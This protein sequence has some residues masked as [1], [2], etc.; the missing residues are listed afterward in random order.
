MRHTA[1]CTGSFCKGNRMSF[2]HR[3]CVF[4]LLGHIYRLGGRC[5][6]PRLGL[7]RRPSPSHPQADRVG[8]ALGTAHQLYRKVPLVGNAHPCAFT[9]RLRPFQTPHRK[10]T[11]SS[12]SVARMTLNDTIAGRF[13]GVRVTL[14]C[15][16]PPAP[17]WAMP[18]LRVYAW[19]S[20]G[21]APP[22]RRRL[23]PVQPV[24][25]VRSSPNPF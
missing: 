11:A 14:C 12:G 9:T 19:L 17:W 3:N 5:P 18:T 25:S 22:T 2:R 7:M 24:P 23:R 21:W 10:C 6:T 4:D 1:R 15:Q 8:T 13:F 16:V 20:V